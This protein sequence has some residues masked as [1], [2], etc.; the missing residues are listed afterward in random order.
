[1]SDENFKKNQLGVTRD[2]S[3][4]TSTTDYGQ[5]QNNSF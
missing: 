3:N 5:L 2:C 1:M 4:Q